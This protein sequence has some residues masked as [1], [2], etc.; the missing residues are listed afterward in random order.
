MGDEWSIRCDYHTYISLYYKGQEVRCYNNKLE[1]MENIIKS[2]E[3]RTHLKFNEIKIIGNKEDFNGL[4][5][6]NH[7]FRYNWL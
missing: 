7:G 6:L 5:F 2:I 3:K 4:K 1:Y